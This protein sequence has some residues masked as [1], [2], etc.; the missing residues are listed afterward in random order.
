MFGKTWLQKTLS[1]LMVIILVLSVG[2]SDRAVSQTSPRSNPAA[3]SA[4]DISEVSPPETIQ[5]LRQ[6]LEGYQ[7]QVTIVS[8]QPDEVLQDNTLTARFQVQDLPIFKHPQL[9]LGPHL[10]VILDNQP[11][12]AVYDLNQPLVLPDLA[13]GTHTLRVFASRPWNESF[14]NEGAYAQTTFHVFAKTQDNNPD[15]AQPLLTYSYPQGSYGAEP[16]L[17]DFYLTN[18]PLHLAAQESPN[19][20][21][22]DW[23]IRCTVNS[24]SFILDRWQSIYL[25]GFKPGKN[26]VQLEF[27]DEKGNTV[28]NVFNS[29]I[30]LINYEQNGKD[31]LSKIVRGELS[32]TEARGIVE[33]KPATPVLPPPSPVIE[34]TPDQLSE[35]KPPEIESVPTE[36]KE[37]PIKAEKPTGGFFNRSRRPNPTPSPSLPTLPDVKP[38]AEPIAPQP[39][40]PEPEPSIAPPVEASPALTPV[41][42]DPQSQA[43]Q[44]EKPKPGGFFQRL[45]RPSI[46]PYP[47]SPPTLPEIIEEPIV[48]PETTKVPPPSVSPALAPTSVEDKPTEPLNGKDPA[49]DAKVLV[50]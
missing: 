41:P 46:K 9:D 21:I 19:D 22:A 13:P 12:L 49:S 33:L 27:L 25:T 44:I 10:Q 1:S 20:A 24:N 43:E 40:T 23:R 15:P 28:K 2:C 38:T 34:K 37:E 6:A 50:P 42:L 14:K 11:S 18:A 36:A 29:T 17:L 31:T 39:D 30:R 5:I 3:P 16:I 4:G 47:S 26:W 32:A 45:R 35:D 8:P 48:V 7:P